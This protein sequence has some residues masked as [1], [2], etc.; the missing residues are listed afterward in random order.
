MT[1]GAVRLARGVM[2]PRPDLLVGGAPLRLLRLAPAGVRA[3][4]SLL[5]GEPA[6]SADRLLPRLLA[7]GMVLPEPANGAPADVTVVIPVRGHAREARTVLEGVPAGVRAVVVDDGSDPPLALAGVEVVRRAVP[8]GPA[9][10]R[11]DG[12]ARATTPLVAFLD[13][14]IRLPD[15][16]LHR[17]SGH[18]ADEHVVA[19]APR[20]RSTPAPGLVGVLEEQLAALDMGAAGGE[21]GR[22]TCL[23]YVPSAVLLVRR[24]VF[25][26]VGGF[27]EQ[28]RVGEDVDLVWR[29]AGFGAVRYDPAVQV[30]HRAR[31]TLLSALRRR[32]DYGTSAAGLDVRHPG[33][34]RHLVLS[35]WAAASWCAALVHPVLGA[36]VGVL[37]V[38]RAP[39]ALP[40]LPPGVARQLVASR[41]LE[42]A[43]RTGR[44]AL[45]PGL[46]LVL[47]A[48]AASPRVRRLLPVLAVAYAWSV[49]ND[50]AGGP[51]RA[52]LRVA[53]DV[54]YSAG[55]WQG[56][57]RRGRWR[58]LLPAVRGWR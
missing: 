29:L 19:V 12:A 47:A 54:S 18:F 4:D 13:G 24:E 21:V 42:T 3:L 8:G 58:P 37:A 35:P 15:G 53:D 51:T 41:Q 39:A 17:L 2:R 5:S 10:A 50:V 34:V 38:A 49:R 57:L 23:S 55:V 44:Y 14:D 27:D 43:G 28:L 6:P 7:A 31:T 36:A 16:W 9:A 20:I 46:P 26:D 32:G 33:Q 40:S 52:A 22:G 56:C 48:G 30:R 45:R 11:N 25:T 1:D